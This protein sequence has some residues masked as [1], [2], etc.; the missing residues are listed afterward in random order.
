MTSKGI[1]ED[2]AGRMKTRDA[3]G[4]FLTSDGGRE[5][6]HLNKVQQVVIG[7]MLRA[8]NLS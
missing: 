5:E 4:I 8:G 6:Q 1:L 3:S 7:E 2:R